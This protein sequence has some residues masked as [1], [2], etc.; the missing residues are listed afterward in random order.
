M[1]STWSFG[2]VKKPHKNKTFH[3]A[4][5]YGETV[6]CYVL[7]ILAWIILSR[8]MKENRNAAG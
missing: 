2:T 4:Q 8:L 6:F 7:L 3:K 5:Q 1:V